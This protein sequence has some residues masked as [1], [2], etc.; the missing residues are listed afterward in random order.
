MMKPSHHDTYLFLR[1]RAEQL[2]TRDTRKNA[3]ALMRLIDA[4][5]ARRFAACLTLPVRAA[6]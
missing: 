5:Q 3:Y 1:K 6:K 2:W 4:E